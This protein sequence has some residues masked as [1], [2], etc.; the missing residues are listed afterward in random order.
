M[1]HLKI[2]C[3][4]SDQIDALMVKF[5]LGSFGSFFTFNIKSFQHILNINVQIVKKGCILKINYKK[6]QA[7]ITSTSSNICESY[8]GG[9][10]QDNH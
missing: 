6:K 5:G 7:S 10:N 4:S 3:K 2:I 9:N 8:Y 1:R